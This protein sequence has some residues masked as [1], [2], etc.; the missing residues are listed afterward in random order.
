M[1]K[2]SYN[3]GST[4]N[5]GERRDVALLSIKA[6]AILR[7]FVKPPTTPVTI[8]K[9]QVKILEETEEHYNISVLKYYLRNVLN[10]RYKKGSSRP[11]KYQEYR[12][13]LAK[14]LF[15]SELLQMILNGETLINVDESSFDRSIRNNYSWLPKGE[16]NPIGNDRVWGKSTLILATWNTWEWF[17]AIIVGTVDS[18][19]FCIFMKL[20][21]LIV[22]VLHSDDAEKPTVLID[23]ARTHTSKAARRIIHNLSYK[24]RYLAP[25]CPEIAPVEQAFGLIK[26]KLRAY[27]P[28]N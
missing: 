6:E 19:K 27:N 26:S 8:K 15:W 24:T 2:K 17:G 13:Q 7:K 22:K 11:L 3:F 5:P 20:L 14:S 18:E 21:E 12:T 9:I 16:D 1:N 25:Y 10:Y 23:N 4:L 28:Y